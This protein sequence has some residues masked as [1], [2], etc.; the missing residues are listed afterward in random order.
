MPHL[1]NSKT[2]TKQYF[3]KALL[4]TAK[5]KNIQLKNVIS[6]FIKAE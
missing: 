2:K 1:N 3:N 6:L 4:N 5:L